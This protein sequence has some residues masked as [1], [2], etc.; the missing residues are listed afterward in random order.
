MH[1][2]R[3]GRPRPQ[4]NDHDRIRH[5][6]ERAALGLAQF[7]PP[8]G[9]FDGFHQNCQRLVRTS[10]TFSQSGNRLVRTGIDQQLI[11]SDTAQRDDFA[12]AQRFDRYVDRSV[13]RSQHRDTVDD[14][15]RG[16]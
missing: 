8:R 15:T 13:S 2:R 1:E 5:V 4:T 3:A 9:M 14:Q 10:F 6:V 16:R 12:A 11:P 7:G